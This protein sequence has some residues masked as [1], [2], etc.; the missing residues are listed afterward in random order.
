MDVNEKTAPEVYR[1]VTDLLNI[2][3]HENTLSAIDSAIEVLKK[4]DPKTGL[5]GSLLDKVKSPMPGAIPNTQAPAAP[6]AP[7]VQKMGQNEMGTGAMSHGVPSPGIDNSSMQ[8]FGKNMKG[9]FA[10][11]QMQKAGG[12]AP[13]PMAPNAMQKHRPVPT[14]QADAQNIMRQGAQ[15]SA[16]QDKAAKLKNFFGKMHQYNQKKK[17]QH[18]PPASQQPPMVKAEG[19]GVDETG[20]EFKVKETFQTEKETYK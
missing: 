15:Q 7:P 4:V 6:T 1:I 13:S 12:I 8:T 5:S 10:K 16:Q 14:P 17:L 3:K 9:Y 20:K 2:K 19:G 11:K 18:R